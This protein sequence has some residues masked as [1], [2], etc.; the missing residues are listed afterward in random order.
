MDGQV[1]EH[2]AVRDD[3]G[4]ARQVGWIPPTPTFLIMRGRDQDARK[5]W[6]RSIGETAGS[7]G[8]VADWVE[9]IEEIF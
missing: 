3:Q 8:A 9:F 6:Q 7:Q 1:I 2:W 4:M 5:A